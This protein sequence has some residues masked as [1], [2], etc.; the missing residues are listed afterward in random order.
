MINRKV[1]S[2]CVS[3]D[4][5]KG[6]NDAVSEIRNNKYVVFTNGELHESDPEYFPAVGT[7]GKVVE[8][9]WD[10]YLV[11]WPEG[12][13]S[14]DDTWNVGYNNVIVLNFGG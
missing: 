11:E 5:C 7:V 13:T 1:M 2:M 3:I 8:E 6:W 12:T 9:D 14:D 4:Y 10:R